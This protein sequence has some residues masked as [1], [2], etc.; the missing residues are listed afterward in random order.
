[1]IHFKRINGEQSG[2]TIIELLIATLIFST[3]LLIATFAVIQISRTYIKGFISSQTENTTRSVIDDVTQAI[4]LSGPTSVTLA[5]SGGWNAFCINGVR[6]TY[7]LNVELNP[8]LGPNNTNVFV[9][10]QPASGNCTP[11]INY[12]NPGTELLSTNERLVNLSLNQ[13]PGS[14]NLYQI[15]LSILYGNDN[16][17][18]GGNGKLCLDNSIGGSFCS[19][20]TTSTTIE[21]RQ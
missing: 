15:D 14:A 12:A 11:N 17:T 5:S 19:L 8:T 4:Q 7:R 16:V 1:M 6:Y 21:E 2:F 13:V 20:S 9:R 3:V 10:D 18:I